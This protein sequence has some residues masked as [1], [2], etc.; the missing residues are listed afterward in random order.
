MSDAES[1][2]DDAKS[3]KKGGKGLII[4]LA[5]VVLLGTGGGGA[6]W[7][8]GRGEPDEAAAERAEE[9]RKAARLFVTLDPF[10][11]NLADRDAERYAQIGVVLEVEGKEVESKLAAKMPAVRNELLLLISSKPASRLTSREGKEELA[12]EIALAAAR[13]LGWS[14]SEGEPEEDEPPRKVKTKDGANAKDTKATNATKAPK[15]T[16]RVRRA[17][18]P[19]PIANVHFASFIVQ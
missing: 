7:F 8:L 14:P 17:E 11:V 4:G 18:S 19:N 9:K 1:T 5:A 3:R 12:A 6:W 13:R 16:P 2:K 15:G 10:V